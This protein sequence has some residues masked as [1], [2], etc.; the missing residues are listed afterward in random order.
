M[1]QFKPVPLFKA[2]DFNRYQWTEILDRVNPKEYWNYYHKFQAK[3][4]DYQLSG[5]TLGQ[6]IFQF[7]SE[8]TSVFME[9]FGLNS[10]ST[11][12][13]TIL[14]ETMLGVLSDDQLAL[15]RS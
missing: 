8:I 2:E 6:E 1:S 11:L 3:A 10:T 14:P 4:K 9:L 5:D 7:L 13:E 12:E 15:L